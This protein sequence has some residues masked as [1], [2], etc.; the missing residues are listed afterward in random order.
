MTCLCC[1]PTAYWEQRLFIRN[2]QELWWAIRCGSWLAKWL[3][4]GRSRCVAGL[5]PQVAKQQPHPLYFA[6]PWEISIQGAQGSVLTVPLDVNL[7]QT[8]YAVIV[9]QNI[10]KSPCHL[11]EGRL[12]TY[13]RT[14]MML[15]QVS[16]FWIFVCLI[17][18]TFTEE[19]QTHKVI[20][21]GH[22]H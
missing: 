6:L 2:K 22:K 8:I 13:K 17:F 16:T 7:V 11:Q 5:R 19:V 12:R 21:Q 20:L 18:M 3:C 15:L 1:N 9:K 4:S 10:I 14:C